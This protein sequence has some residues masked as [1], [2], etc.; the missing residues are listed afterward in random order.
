MNAS[1]T[2]KR[3]SFDLQQRRYNK[4]KSWIASDINKYVKKDFD[5]PYIEAVC[6]L[7]LIWPN[8]KSKSF[9][10]KMKADF[11][12]N[13]LKFLKNYPLERFDIRD[14]SYTKKVYMYQR[15]YTFEYV[16]GIDL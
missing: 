6:N 3:N 4:V 5:A 1:V 13:Y 11:S 12:K 7:H 8:I 15:D 10:D 2:T 16:F 14:Y 9:T